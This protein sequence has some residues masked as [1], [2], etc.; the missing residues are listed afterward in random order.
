MDPTD[1]TRKTVSVTLPSGICM[2]ERDRPKITAPP[3]EFF[4]EEALRAAQ[5]ALG[6]NHR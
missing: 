6:E 4:M 5:R 3:D 2:S 1:T